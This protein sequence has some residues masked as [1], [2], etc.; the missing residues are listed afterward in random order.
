MRPLIIDMERRGPVSPNQMITDFHQLA[1]N[2]HSKSYK[3]LQP[4]TITIPISPSVHQATHFHCYIYICMYV[5]VFF[6]FIL[7]DLLMCLMIITN[8]P[9]DQLFIEFLSDPEV[10]GSFFRSEV[11]AAENH[12]L[13]SGETLLTD[14]RWLR[15]IA[16]S[17]IYPPVIKHGWLGNPLYDGSFNGKINYE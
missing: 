11:L 1:K 5:C 6:S 10:T 13:I 7:C 14:E 17:S 15:E 2:P 16:C 8:S 4:Q 3:I 9:I 12:L